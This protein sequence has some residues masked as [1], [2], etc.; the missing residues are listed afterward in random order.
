MRWFDVGEDAHGFIALGQL[1][2]GFIAV[3]QMATGVVA[4]GQIARGVIAVGQGAI[5][6]VAFG[7]GAVGLYYGVGMVGIAG[8]GFGLVIP[9]FPSLGAAAVAPDATTLDRVVS[10]EAP[11]WVPV[12]ARRVEGQLAR[13][14][15]P[16][17]RLLPARVDI[18]LKE[19]VEA[20]ADAPAQTLLGWAEPSPAGPVIA[21]LIAIPRSRLSRPGWWAIWGLQLGALLVVASA[22]WALALYPVA[23]MLREGF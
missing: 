19:A 18:R 15:D 8:R 22:V 17:G 1:A 7:Q 9:L 3:G 20:A 10:R 12:V 5:G 6:V 13:L 16:G 4:I 11:G 21:R 23:M 2:T 14:H